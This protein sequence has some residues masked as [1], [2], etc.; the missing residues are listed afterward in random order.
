MAM[1]KNLSTELIMEIFEAYENGWSAAKCFMSLGIRRNTFNNY[2]IGVYRRDCYASHLQKY[3]E[4]RIASR[5]KK[6]I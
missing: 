1:N 3:P 2:L 4:G 5:R 6:T